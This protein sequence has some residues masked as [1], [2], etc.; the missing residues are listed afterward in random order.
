[1]LIFALMSN[2]LNSL[3]YE[4]LFTQPQE[5]HQ[6]KPSEL[7]KEN[8][9]LTLHTLFSSGVSVS[10]DTHLSSSTDLKLSFLAGIHGVCVCM[11]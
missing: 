9:I 4:K 7:I 2:W 8:D 5:P 11:S 6:S 3:D 1:M 10:S